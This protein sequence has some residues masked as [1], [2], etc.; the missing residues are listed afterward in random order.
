MCRAIAQS[1][2]ST[3][4]AVEL[5]DTLAALPD[6]IYAYRLISGNRMSIVKIVKQS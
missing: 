1:G 4:D 6:G 5:N 3:G 2:G